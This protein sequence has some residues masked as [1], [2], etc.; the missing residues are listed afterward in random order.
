MNETL[1]TKFLEMQQRHGTIQIKCKGADELPFDVIK[2]FQGKLKKLSQENAIRLATSLF[3]NGFCAPFFIWENGGERW[4]IDGH[5]RATVLNS[6]REAGIILPNLFPVCFIDAENEA[7]ARQKLLTITS[8]YGEFQKDQLDEW[9]AGL[10]EEIK[11][12]LSLMD[13]EINTS[14]K[15]ETNNDDEIE[16]VKESIIKLGDIIELGRHRLICETGEKESTFE[17]LMQEAKADMC[18]TD[19]PYGV[20][21]GDKNKLLDSI[22][23]GGRIKTNIENDTMSPEALKQIL[24]SCFVNLKAYSAD[25][26]SYY[27]TAPQGGELGMMMMM[28][29]IDSGLPVRHILIWGKNKPTF[30]MGRLDYDYKHEPI[31]YTWNKKHEFYGKGLHKSS[32]WNIDKENKCDIHPTMKPVELVENAI[33]NSSLPEQIV[34]DPFLGSGTSIIACEKTNRIC[35]GIELDPHYCDVIIQRYKDW[36][37]N[38]NRT[39][40]VKINGVICP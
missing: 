13:R 39:I 24:V 5:Q 29:M 3:I 15:I 40:V 28:M 23:K 7:D 38:N 36:C 33:L 37:N 11:E 18:F 10:D 21:I 34:V 32:I 6:M 27:V 1:K 19:P 2:N 26:C 17:T 20:A 31:L 4:C 22:Q 25:Y 8:Q 14:T 16:E 35:Y 12:S 30:S 9:L